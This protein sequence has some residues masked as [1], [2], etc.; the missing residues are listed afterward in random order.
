MTVKPN[1]RWNI[2]GLNYWN[3]AYAPIDASEDETDDE[4]EGSV[5]LDTDMID[6]L[7]EMIGSVALGEMLS[8]TLADAPATVAL[9]SAAASMGFG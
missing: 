2:I 7:E 4:D 1:L 9:V 5:Y 3:T 6:Q 8:M